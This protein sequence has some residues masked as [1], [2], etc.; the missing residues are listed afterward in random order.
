MADTEEYNELERTQAAL[1][2][3]EALVTVEVAKIDADYL[4]VV[5][6]G[7]DRSHSGF[8]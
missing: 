8:V 2:T 5:L 1:I 3:A 6:G 4:C 7:L